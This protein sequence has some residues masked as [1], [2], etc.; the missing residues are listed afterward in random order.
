VL[1]YMKN[2]GA[3]P[4]L[5]KLAAGAPEARLTR[6]ATAARERLNQP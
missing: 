2:E 4:L 5:K 1:E 3:S 6:E